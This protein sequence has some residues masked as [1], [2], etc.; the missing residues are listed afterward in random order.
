MLFLVLAVPLE[1]LV[2]PINQLTNVNVLMTKFSTFIL[3]YVG[4]DVASR[5][6]YYTPNQCLDRT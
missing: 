5:Y 3:W 4:F 6:N 2:E 1:R